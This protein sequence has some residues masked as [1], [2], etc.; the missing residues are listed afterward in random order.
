MP[1]PKLI[2]PLLDGLEFGAAVQTEGARSTY[3]MRD[4][5]T[6]VVY[7]L[8]IT[9]IPE[10]E[11]QIDALIYSGAVADREEALR[12]Y[13]DLILDIRRELETI[14]GFADYDGIQSHVDYQ[15]EERPEGQGFEVYVLSE[16]LP[17][18]AQHISMNA[19]TRLEALNLGLDLCGAL[20]TL[21]E[22]GYL[23]QNVSPDTIL[24]TPNGR[25]ELSNLSL[26]ELERLSFYS[27]AE[28][29]LSPYSAP[30]LC[31]LISNFHPTSDLYSVGLVLYYLFNGNHIPFVD[32]RTS[33]AA[34]DKRRIEGESLPVPMYADYELSEII[35]K[36][37]AFRPEDRYQSP[38]ELR[39]VLTQYMQ[40]NPVSD[41]LIVPPICTEPEDVVSA[42]AEEEPVEPISFARAEELDDDFVSYLSPSQETEAESIPEPEETA[43][44]DSELNP[45]PHAAAPQRRKSKK[46]LLI[47]AV[48][49]LCC[50][51]AGAL[52]YFLTRPALVEITQL[53]ATAVDT[54]SITVSLQASDADVPLRLHCTD[55]YGNASTAD[56]SGEAVTFSELSAGTQYAISIEAPE[57]Q[58]LEGSTTIN[59]TT[60]EAAELV[61]ITVH[62]LG[63]HEATLQLNLN[64][65]VPDAWDI[66]CEA[67]GME[68]VSHTFSGTSIEI[69]GLASNTTYTCTFSDA[70]GA[71]VSGETSVT[72]TT[73]PSVTLESFEVTQT[74]ADSVTLAWSYSGD[75]PSSWTVRCEG[76]NGFSDEQQVAGLSTTFTG[77]SSDSAYTFTITT[78]G[79]EDT[80]LSTLQVST[81]DYSVQSLTASPVS[82]DSI[83]VS[84]V[85]EGGEEGASW[86]VTYRPSSSEQEAQSITTTESTVTLTG[87][88]PGTGYSIELRDASGNALAGNSTAYAM[89]DVAERYTDHGCDN[90]YMALYLAPE[91]EN[92]TYM[93]LATLRDTFAPDESIAVAI[94][95]VSG[96]QSADEEISVL[97]VIRDADGAPV[98]TTTQ[99]AQWADLWTGNLHTAQ[100]PQTPQQAGEYEMEVYF[101]GRL[102]DNI[103]FTVS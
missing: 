81:L 52:V 66:S 68:P 76:A 98:A 63:K 86:L 59:V 99:T 6:G 20:Y 21:H 39:A 57:G 88:I 93:D 22:S 53:Q 101:N 34:A 73:E 79:L 43:L 5:R 37:C 12:Y 42:A 25:F 95:S 94:E 2:S 89:T 46:P 36:A 8:R 84:F 24:L 62:E 28:D 31:G 32:E 33:P 27:I 61:S 72:F 10:S 56:Y 44:P 67:E 16:Y 103:G 19:V 83:E 17:S 58:R 65:A 97:Y 92:W 47:A 50:I 49:L 64:G 78:V 96:I 40:R 18:L 102:L 70:S 23:V 11:K 13:T 14:R 48:L 4:T 77:I 100:G 7:L 69:T 26:A 85:I 3:L 41:D 35:L 15:I 80:Q 82:S 71:P 54:A 90:L 38:E 1:E 51:A 87:L 60:E 45:E 29:R 75:A 91:A 74:T 30:E 55:A 9:A